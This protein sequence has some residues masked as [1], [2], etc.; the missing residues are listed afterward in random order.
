MVARAALSTPAFSSLH[1][2]LDNPPTA[3]VQ[4]S[5]SIDSR[6]PSRST[7]SSSPDKSAVGYNSR[8]VREQSVLKP[9]A[10]TAIGASS[11]AVTRESAVSTGGGTSLAKCAKAGHQNC[12]QAQPPAAARKL[13]T[14]MSQYIHTS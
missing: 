13:K 8:A 3:V 12:R 14:D 7:V 10:V 9:T 2:S 5:S 4:K 1:L 11:R 6:L